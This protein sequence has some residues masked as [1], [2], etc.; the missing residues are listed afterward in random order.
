M[1]VPIFKNGELVYQMPSL[2][3]RQKYCEEE[4]KSLYPE[5]TRIINPHEYYVDLSD[6]LRELKDVLI[7]QKRQITENSK[8]FFKK[9]NETK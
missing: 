3:E 1:L 9:R 7:D 5:V 6:N 4:H 2:G 8:Q